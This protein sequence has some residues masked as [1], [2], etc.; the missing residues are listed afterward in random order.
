MENMKCIMK[1]RPMWGEEP[2]N[3]GPWG[4]PSVSSMLETAKAVTAAVMAH[5]GAPT[6]CEAGEVVV[7]LREEGEPPQVMTLDDALTACDGYIALFIDGF[8]T[9][10]MTHEIY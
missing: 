1:P 8:G 7:I 10:N 6:R 3:A 9:V 5:T 4:C 2:T